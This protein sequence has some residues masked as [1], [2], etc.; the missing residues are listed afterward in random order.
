MSVMAEARTKHYRQELVAVPKALAAV[1]R[2]V[3]AQLRHWGRG[4]LSSSAVLCATELLS[5]VA[6]HA[7]SPECVLLVQSRPDAVRITVSDVSRVLPVIVEPDWSSQNGRGMFLL[8]A[9]ADAWGAEPTRFGKDVWVE[10]RTGAR[11]AGA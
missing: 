8:A 2:I 4:E 6:K 1:R 3:A 11:E 10:F 7:A 5:N 9:T